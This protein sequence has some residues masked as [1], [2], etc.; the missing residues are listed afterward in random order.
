MEDDNN[1]IDDEEPQPSNRQILQKWRLTKYNGGGDLAFRA[2]INTI[3]A[4]K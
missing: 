4:L 1:S 2:V 3:T